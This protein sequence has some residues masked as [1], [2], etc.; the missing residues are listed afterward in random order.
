[1][2]AAIVVATT[3][4]SSGCATHRA[5]WGWFPAATAR[6]TGPAT[7]TLAAIP[8]LPLAVAGGVLTAPLALADRR[9]ALAGPYVALLLGTPVVAPFWLIGRA[10]DDAATDHSKDFDHTRPEPLPPRRGPSPAP[11]RAPPVR[12][13]AEAWRTGRGGR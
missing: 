7:F 11:D 5:P 6:G 12:A 2:L 10:I 3:G 8:G 1:M 9:G 4:L 13:P